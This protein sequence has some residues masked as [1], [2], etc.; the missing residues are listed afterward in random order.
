MDNVRASTLAG[1]PVPTTLGEGM[2]EQD[3][4]A[5]ITSH[6]SRATDQINELCDCRAMVENLEVRLFGQKPQ[7]SQEGSEAAA[8]VDGLTDSLGEV[9]DEITRLTRHIK[10]KLQN[11][12]ESL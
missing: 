7:Q 3:R 12:H 11:I 5:S 2:V 1:G 8:Q 10:T 9:V 6:I 4:P